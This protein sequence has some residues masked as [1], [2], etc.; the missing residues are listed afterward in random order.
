MF[1]YKHA[2]VPSIP[3]RLRFKCKIIS[4]NDNM[5][6]F[7]IHDNQ[8]NILYDYYGVYINTY[9]FVALHLFLTEKCK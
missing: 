3:P 6:S 5:P 1:R 9:H 8:D 4:R 7:R 2:R